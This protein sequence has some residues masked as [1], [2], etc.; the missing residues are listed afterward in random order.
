TPVTQEAWNQVMD[1]NP[2]EFRGPDLPVE[3]VS[4]S[5]I[6]EYCYRSGTRLP[7][8]AEWEYAAR[9]NTITS[10]YGDAD[11]ISWHS[12]NSGGMTRPVGQK[13]SNGFGLFDMLGNVWECVADNYEAEYPSALQVDPKGPEQGNLRVIRGGAWRYPPRYARASDRGRLM[14][15]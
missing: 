10:R 11:E 9:G 13:L 12:G 6:A 15:G 14:P 7:T 5:E 4:L 8:E 2:S 3:H 1:S